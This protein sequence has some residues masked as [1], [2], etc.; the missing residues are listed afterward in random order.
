MDIQQKSR[1]LGFIS[2]G[3]GS[4]AALLCLYPSIRSLLIALP[5]GFAGMVC[6]GAYIF[7]DTKHE[8]NTK[9]LTPGII[10]LMLSSAPVLL[11]LA[12]IIINYFNH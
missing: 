2:I 6:S 5:V 3:V 9:K 4:I 7:I 8:I 12:F 1:L 10:G 11:I